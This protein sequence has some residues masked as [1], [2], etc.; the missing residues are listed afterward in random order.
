MGIFPIVI[1]PLQIFHWLVYFKYLNGFRNAISD[2]FICVVE[3]IFMVAG[4]AL[5]I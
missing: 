1:C 4:K 3:Y 5:M 2:H